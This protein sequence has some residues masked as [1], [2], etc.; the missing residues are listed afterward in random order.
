MAHFTHISPAQN[1]GV[2]HLEASLEDNRVSI[3]L[4]VH[5]AD[6][7]QTIRQVEAIDVAMERLD[8]RSSALVEVLNKANRQGRLTADILARLQESGQ[9]F[10]DELFSTGLK[11]RLNAS[12]EETLVLT[13]DDALM[14]IPWE[15]LHDG[16]QFLGHRFA[17]GR[18]VRTRQT[19]TQAPERLLASPLQMLVLADPC[20]DLKCAYDE[21]IHI[22]NL[23]E[24]Y[25]NQLQVTFRSGSV[26]VDWLKTRLRR[27]DLV[28]YAGHADFDN[29]HPNKTGWRIGNGY[30][31]CADIQSMTGTG[32]MPPLVF[33]NAC[34]SARSRPWTLNTQ[35]FDLAN[36]FLISGVKHY[37]GTFWDIPDEAARLFSKCFYQSL[38]KGQSIGAAVRSARHDIITE[39]GEASMVW[40]GYL[41]Y[42]DPAT[43]Y[44]KTNQQTDDQPI[45]KQPQYKQ[46]AAPSSAHMRAPKESLNSS[47]FKKKR[48]KR[49]R[50]SIY[51]TLLFAILMIGISRLPMGS[52]NAA[53][54]EQ[55]A[56]AAFKSGQY[57]QVATVCA[58]LQRRQPQRALSYVL[59]ASVY[60]YQG[61][62]EKSETLYQQAL[63]TDQEANKEKAE[64]FIGLGRI[65][66]VR[67]HTDTALDFYTKAAQLAPANETPLL[68]QALLLN[69]TGRSDQAVALLQQAKTITTDPQTLNALAFRIQANATLT[70]QRE[71]QVRI[72]QLIEELTKRMKD[73]SYATRSKPNPPPN[74]PLTIWI[75]DFETIG[76][77]LKEGH[78]ILLESGLTER[79][80]QIKPIRVVERRMLENLMN[81]LKQGASTLTDPDTRLQL[82]RLNAAQIIVAGRVVHTPPTMQITLRGIETESSQVFAIVNAQFKT[83]TPIAKIVDQLATDLIA[84]IQKKY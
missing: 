61:N 48:T 56:L 77:T 11:V 75:S 41:L 22:R 27:F 50:F 13:L 42:G 2:L 8:Q 12:T 10:R 69:N 47:A 58:D 43:I 25:P 18:V 84:K 29:L 83:D 7:M 80:L 40:A 73:A 37:L 17:M 76:P 66:S 6:E 82:G 34:Q 44:F 71:R 35:M 45:A 72:D 21:G 14:H 4:S 28:H 24:A 39:F 70:A 26:Q 5:K 49:L 53:A 74:R 33:A 68:A 15:L 64:A 63:E 51:A 9:L 32:C 59:L 81:E 36:A 54:S 3:S 19:V 55:A 1:Q 52:Q 23:T 46:P 78:S 79:L 65:A 60:F 20:G 38:L 67:G 62:L 57:D 16:R 31:T 30:L